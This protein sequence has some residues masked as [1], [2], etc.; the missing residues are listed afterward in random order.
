VKRSAGNE[1]HVSGANNLRHIAPYLAHRFA[2]AAFCP[3]E[4]QNGPLRGTAALLQ[5]AKRAEAR[6]ESGLEVRAIAQEGCGYLVHPA[7]RPIG[8]GRV[9]V[10]AGPW[11]GHIAGPAGVKLPVVA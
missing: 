10:A 11:S 1:Y 3:A 8:A 2:G 7:Q 6:L 5:L 4:G 9:V